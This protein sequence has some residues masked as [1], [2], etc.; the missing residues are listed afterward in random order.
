MPSIITLFQS[1]KV[2]W[3]ILGFVLLLFSNP[4]FAQTLELRFNQEKNAIHVFQKNNSKPLLTQNAKVDFRPYLHPIVAPDGKGVLTQYSPGHHKHQT[5]LYWGFTRVNGRDYFH[6][7]KSDYWKRVSL[8]ILK[9]E[10]PAHKKAVHWQTVYNLLDAKGNPVLRETQDWTLA[11]NNGKY[12]LDLVWSGK[13]NTD[14]TIGKYAYG[15]LFLRMPWT[16]KTKGQALNSALQKNRLAEGQ[17]A[18]WTDVGLEIA[19]RDDQAHIT[20]FDHPKNPNFPNAW[21]VDGQL[22]IGPAPSRLGDLRINQGKTLV[23]RH[24]LLVHTGNLNPVKINEIWSQYT[25]QKP[26]NR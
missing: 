10:S 21:R 4:V 1:T 24:R 16:P 12:F 6:H 13:A 14:V 23:Y 22:G 11:L 25:G 26:T 15:G 7:P 18:R 2:T 9:K 3:P 20:I 17:R 19:G 5:G 8:N